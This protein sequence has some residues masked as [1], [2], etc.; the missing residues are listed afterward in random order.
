MLIRYYLF[1][2]LF[3]RYYCSIDS[4]IYVILFKYTT[5]KTKTNDSIF[6]FTITFICTY[7][8]LIFLL[9]FIY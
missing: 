8:Y 3:C 5:H 1:L 4:P 2:S 9:K 7:V 6:F